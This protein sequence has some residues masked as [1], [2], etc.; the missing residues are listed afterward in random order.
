MPKR[1][2]NFTSD[3]ERNYPF[4]KETV[5]SKVLWNYCQSVFSF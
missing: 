5:D 2:C 3:I 1:K 4:L